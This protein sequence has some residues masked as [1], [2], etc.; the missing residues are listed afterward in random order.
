MGKRGPKAPAPTKP[1]SDRAFSEL[2]GMIKIQCTRDEICGVIG[3][4]EDTLNRRLK[5]RGE[6]NFA[7]LYKKNQHEGR[8]SL[9]RDQWKSSQGGN[10]TMQIWLGKQVLEQRDKS[11][12]DQKNTLTITLASDTDDL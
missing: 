12:V 2:V 4:S 8:A 7:A 1:L 10:V 6:E 3:M 5:E 11:D 9:R